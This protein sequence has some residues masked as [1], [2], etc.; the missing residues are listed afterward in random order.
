[1]TGPIE[2]FTEPEVQ[3]QAR[4]V[5]RHVLS[6][7]TAIGWFEQIGQSLNPHYALINFDYDELSLMKL[8]SM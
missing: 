1:M 2:E 8:G 3:K 4:R 5:S 6:E 7:T